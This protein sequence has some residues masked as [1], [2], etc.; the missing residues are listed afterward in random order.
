M[1]KFLYFFVAVS[2]LGAAEYGTIRGRVVDAETQEPIPNTRVTIS[3]IDLSAYTDNNGEYCIHFIPLGTYRVVAEAPWY[4]RFTY[5]HVTVVGTHVFNFSM[6]PV[7]LDVRGRVVETHQPVID[8]LDPLNATVIT[9]NTIKNLPVTTID[10][11]MHVQPG[12]VKSEMGLHERGGRANENAYYI[13]GIQVPAHINVTS[14]EIIKAYTRGSD[15]EYGNALAGAV[16]M[17]TKPGG[18]RNRGSIHYLTDDFS[19]LDRLNFGYNRYDMILHGPLTRRLRYI[20]SGELTFVDAFQEALYRIESPGNEYNMYG[21][22]SY[23]LPHGKGRICLSGLRAR[24]QQVLWSPYT[25]PSN[26]WKYAESDVMS[27]TKQWFGTLSFDYLLTNKT[28]AA[29]T[30]GIV[31]QDS[32]YGNRDYEWEE[33]HNTEWYDDYRL[34]AE[35]LISLMHNDSYPVDILVDSLMEYHEAPIR[36]G[37]NILRQSPFGITG[38]FYLAGDFPVWAYQKNSNVQMRLNVMHSLSRTFELKLGG[39]YTWHTLKYFYN[40]MPYIAS[41]QWDYYHTYES[42]P[43]HAAAY[44]QTKLTANYFVA[45][46]GARLDHYK[47]LDIPSS[48][49][50]W[51]YIGLTDTLQQSSTNVSPRISIALPISPRV[52]FNLNYGHFFQP[53]TAVLPKPLHSIVTDCGIEVE[54]LQNFVFSTSLYL[55][56]M[57]DLTQVR[58]IIVESLS[59]PEARYQYFFTDQVSV[60]GYEFAIRK[61]FP[62][63]VSL[64][65]SYNLQY[66]QNSNY[67]DGPVYMNEYAQPGQFVRWEEHASDYDQRH[68]FHAHITVP[69]P[70]RSYAAPGFTAFIVSYHAG[71]PY[72]PTDLAGHILVGRNAARID[73]YWNV[74]WKINRAFRIGRNRLVF[75]GLV[76]NLFNAKQVVDV[77]TTTGVPDDHGDPDPSP[78]QFASIPFTSSHYSP[79]ADHNHDGL[80][81]PSEGLAEYIAAR[82]SLYEDPTNYNNPFRLRLGIGLEF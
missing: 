73:G 27:R 74:D 55:K 22:L 34:K 16:N 3:E 79:Q 15:V 1:H 48:P 5:T 4:S 63:G 37:S 80:I 62:Q 64:D 56:N 41:T 58:L 33:A 46:L 9:A 38:L 13:D 11:L 25:E 40:G 54:P 2:L 39:D 77:Y 7:L 24:Q 68:T 76:T 23:T 78:G 17:V 8:P 72:T 60:N 10:E 75:T 6:R 35:H 12:F 20:V 28:L 43:K 29:L 30:I 67:W 57:Y 49:L 65:F 81:T 44:V 42:A 71:H 82:N 32:V 69:F 21:K 52:K 61:R 59:W 66:A 47:S 14:L 53:Q 18:R 31:H 19:P 36:Y 45:Q 70:K 50:D 51:P 26:N